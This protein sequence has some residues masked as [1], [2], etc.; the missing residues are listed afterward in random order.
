MHDPDSTRLAIPGWMT[1]IPGSDA[2]AAAEPIDKGWSPDR[3]YRIRTRDGGSLLLR[4]SEASTA[5]AKKAEFER[6]RQ[7]FALGIPMSRPLAFGVCD[8][9]DHPDEPEDRGAPEDRNRSENRPFVYSLL[10]WIE[11]KDAQDLLPGLSDDEAYR[12]GRRAG[13]YLHRMHTL[14]A[15]AGTLSPA[16]AL[17]KQIQRKQAAYEQCGYLLPFDRELL[18][19]IEARLPLLE[20][21]A[22]GFRQG[23]YHPGNMI[24]APDGSLHII[25]FNRS[26]YGD[27][28]R[29]FNRLITF[30][31][32]IS[33]PFA[34][35]Q[36][37]GYLAAAP[38]DPHFFGRLSLYCAVESLYAI[39]WAVP[40]GEPEISDTLQR[41]E[42][43]WSD[44]DGFTRDVPVWYTQ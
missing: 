42:Q 8:G 4:V 2:W 44:F 20:N 5:E 41:S 7:A 15:P 18:A 25:D 23:D 14:P 3:K 33:L 11:G 39:V 35:G 28:Y 6:V 43:I 30:T 24:L 17:R 22:P 26:D 34:R 40:F 9:S 12:L 21:V 32:R 27:P 16:A 36:L 10:S 29:D 13:E 37:D 31:S 38:Y 19:Q 1:S